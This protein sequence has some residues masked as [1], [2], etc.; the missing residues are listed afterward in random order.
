MSSSKPSRTIGIMGGMGPSATIDLFQK[1]VQSTPAVRD[2]QHLPILIYNNPAIP[3]RIWE[4][5]GTA[6]SP[7][8][9]LIRC[10]QTLEAAGADFLVMPCHTAHLWISRIR[11][12]ITIPFF[13]MVEHTIAV[14]A[15][16][17][18][19]GEPILLLGTGSTIG[20]RLYPL[21]AVGGRPRFVEPDARDQALVDE[22]ILRMKAGRPNPESWLG[23][24]DAML[25]RYYRA[26]T[27]R[28]LAA[29]TEIP[30]MAPYL[31]S[32]MPLVDPTLLLARLAVDQATR[33]HHS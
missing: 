22:A 28:A 32:A 24:L 30:L 9:A 18:Q 29:C 33:Y 25:E 2:Q 20:Q 16:E 27:P 7:L 11:S 15:V 3:P 17:P 21:A 10:A 1:I 31:E 4:S 19:D 12:Q 23:P 14:L 5:D 8:P 6:D 13:S 26:G